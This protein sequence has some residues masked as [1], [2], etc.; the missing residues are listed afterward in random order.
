M[1]FYIFYNSNILLLKIKKILFWCTFNEK[2]FCKN[3][4]R[5]P[6]LQHLRVGLNFFYHNKKYLGH[7]KLFDIIIKHGLSS[8]L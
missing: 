8:Q 4:Q 2:Y 5:L 3:T 6:T 7:K 1:Y